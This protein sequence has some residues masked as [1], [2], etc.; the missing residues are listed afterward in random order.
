MNNIKTISI[1]IFVLITTLSTGQNQK[2]EYKNNFEGYEDGTDL[3]EP[4]V[5]K[6]L[7]AWGET[8]K[9]IAKNSDGKGNNGSN[10]YAESSKN[11]GV[12]CVKY[13]TLEKGET[14]IWKI[15]VKIEGNGKVNYALKA[16]SG[17]G[18]KAHKYIEQNIDEPE[19]GKWIEYKNEFTVKEGYEKLN[20]Q[21]SRWASGTKLCV[22]DFI[23]KKK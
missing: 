8:T 17:K 11:Q 22:D 3:T 5:K 2:P 10:G 21:V 7:F 12:N 14:Y 6:R 19:I 15:A 16:S 13:F 20:V 4:G 1:S 23:L 9:F 18:D